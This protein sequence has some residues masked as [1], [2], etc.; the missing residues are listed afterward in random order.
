MTSR[1]PYNTHSNQKLLMDQ[2]EQNQVVIRED[3]T[4][5]KAQMGQLIKAIQA[6]ARGQEEMRQSN[7][8]AAT[9]NPAIVTMPV[10]PLGGANTPVMTQPLAERGLVY[11]N[12]AQTFN[13]PVSG[14]AQP[15]IEYNQDAFFTTMADL[16]YDAF[17]PSP[18]DIERK[19]CMM[20]ERFKAIE[21]LDT[22]GLDT[23]DMCLAPGV[24]IPTKFK[25]ILSGA[26]LE[27]YMQLE[28]M[29]IR[30][31]RELAEAFLKQYQYDSDMAPNQTQLQNLVQKSDESFKEYAQRWRDLAARV[32][33]LFLE[34]ELVYMFMDTLQGPYLD[35][36]IGSATLRFLD[37]VI[38]SERIKNCL[39]IDKIQDTIV[40]AS[41]EKK[42]H[43][44]F[45]KK[46]EGETNAAIIA[47]EEAEAY[48][49][50]YY[51]VETVAPNMYQQP[52]YDIPT[53]PPLVRYRQSYAP[54]RKNPYQEGK[55]KSRKLERRMNLIPMSYNQLLAHLLR[56]SLV[57]FR[58][59]RPPPIPLPQGYD[60]NARCEFHSG[61]PRHTVKNCRA[62]KH[63]VQ[64][65]IGSKDISFAPAVPNV[66]NNPMQAI[67]YA[68]P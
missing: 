48:Q 29:R 19:F 21:G 36:I 47:K 5:V 25:D 44:G 12:V 8:R 63:K 56:D 18:V 68:I 9:T 35:K 58:E 40:T 30:T 6:L 16:V 50:L 49:M 42:S 51:Q 10:N 14:R 27:W 64:D 66:T 61:A 57:Q 45:P 28:R 17:G 38:A 3:M 2:L 67:T 24:K 15:E 60:A 33:P 34:R 11:Q 26:S 22:F 13:I 39:K 41:G 59:L 54:Q 43:S 23:A 37:L 62:L 32:Q 55:Q 20:E 46:K 7:M 31:W 1:H 65:L 53:G 52:T 4:T